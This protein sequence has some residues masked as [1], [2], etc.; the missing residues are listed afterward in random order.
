MT[1][2]LLAGLHHNNDASEAQLEFFSAQTFTSHS[3]INHVDILCRPAFNDHKMVKFPVYDGR[4]ADKAKLINLSAQ[5][6]CPY[7]HAIVASCF[8]N[9]QGRESI[10]ANSIAITDFS[11]SGLT[12]IIAQDHG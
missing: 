12:T 7:P 11:N 4:K 3:G 8:N 6:Y 9:I 1:I 10:T 5:R 2:K